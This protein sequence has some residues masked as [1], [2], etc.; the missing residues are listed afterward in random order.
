LETQTKAHQT[1]DTILQ[2]EQKQERVQPE[3]APSRFA[4]F[5]AEYPNKKGRQEAEKTWAKR[6]MDSR[7]DELIAHVRL[8]VQTDSDWLRGYAPMGSTYLNQAR[9]E[10]VPKQQPRAGPALAPPSK[11]LSA[12]QKLQA[13]KHGNVDPQRDSGRPEQAHVL[14]LGADAGR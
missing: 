10:D 6:K 12:I 1:P 4:E 13:M 5:W 8:M 9:W 2:E 14:E 11:T 3:A 7:C